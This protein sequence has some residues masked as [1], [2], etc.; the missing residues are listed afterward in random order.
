[1]SNIDKLLNSYTLAIYRGHI[2]KIY[3]A[4]KLALGSEYPGSIKFDL[5]LAMPQEMIYWLTK[6]GYNLYSYSTGGGSESY[7]LTPIRSNCHPRFYRIR[8]CH[9]VTNIHLIHFFDD[10]LMSI[11]MPPP[12]PPQ[13]PPPGLPHLG[14]HIYAPM[15]FPSQS[16]SYDVL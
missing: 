2:K 7:L 14:E 8:E 1:M 10:C 12:L 4:I 3:E 5:E 9:S 13:L 16:S 6:S 15:S 11:S